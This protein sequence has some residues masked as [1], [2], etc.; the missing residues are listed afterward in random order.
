MRYI[1][2][3]ALIPIFMFGC[4]ESGPESTE[5]ESVRTGFE[6]YRTAMMDGNAS[7]VLDWVD[8]NTLAYYEMILDRVVNADSATV[9]EMDLLDKMMVLQIRQKIPA[10]TVR[11][12]TPRTLFVY[13]IRH[14][15]VGEA[16]LKQMSLGDIEA[17]SLT[18]TG[19]L[20][21]DDKPTSLKFRFSKEYGVW[22]IDLTSLFPQSQASLKR[23]MERNGWD[24]DRLIEFQLDGDLRSGLWEPIGTRADSSAG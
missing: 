4:S 17:D 21:V 5:A 14:G 8:A 2:A 7:V 13:T 24:E 1:I 23:I 9:R 3:L 16:N 20:V 19:Q 15:L 11:D 10:D 12:M 18:A 22:K 6:A